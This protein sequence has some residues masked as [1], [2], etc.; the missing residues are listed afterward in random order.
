M[1]LTS[2]QWTDLSFNPI[3]ARMLDGS[4]RVDGHFCQKLSPGCA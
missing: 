4:N 3:R 1:G 2:I